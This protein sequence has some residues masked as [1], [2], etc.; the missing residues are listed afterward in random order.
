[1]PIYQRGKVWYIDLTTPS[2]KRT[3]FSA[4]TTDRQQAQE[5]HDRLKSESWRESKL[6]DRR[7]YHWEEAALRWL[8]E[9]AHKA[10]LHD[11]AAKIKAFTKYFKGKPLTDINRTWVGEI[12]ESLAKKP[13]TRNRYVA[14]IRAILRK[15]EREWEWIERAPAFRTYREPQRRISWVTGEQAQGLIDELPESYRDVVR[16]ALA[17]GLRQGNILGLRW[18]QVDLRRR[19]AWIFGD[20]AKGGQPIPVA[21]NSDAVAIVRRQ[22]GR[23]LERVFMLRRINSFVWER[24]RKKAGLP[25]FRFHDLRHCWASW[26]LQAG[27]PLPALQEM[28]GWSDVRMVRRYAHLAPE[29]LGP[30]AERIAGRV[31]N[32]GTLSPQEEQQ[33]IG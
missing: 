3:K 15:A 4:R 23:D 5:L 19:V 25:G 14:L 2:G 32:G 30:Y 24:A 12:V 17:T 1:M 9:Q 31:A 8:K 13:G 21:L 27:V 11:D 10:S 22:I 16:F 26:L 33:R 6:G 7:T 18:E 29:H 28:G 20:E